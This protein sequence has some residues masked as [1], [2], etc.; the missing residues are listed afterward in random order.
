M[1]YCPYIWVDRDF[2]LARGWIQGFP[3]KLGSIWMT[4]TFGLDTPAD[5]GIRD[6][7]HVRGDVRRERAPSG[8]GHGDP[9]AGERRRADAQRPADR[10]RPP[11]PAARQGPPRRAG[12]PRAR[13]LARLR[14]LGLGDL[15]GHRRPSSSSTRPTRST[16][17]WRRRGSARASASRSATRST[18][19]RPWKSCERAGHVRVG[20]RGRG[21][22][23]QHRPLHRR[24][25]GRLGRPLRGHQPDRRP[26]AR[27]GRIRRPRRGGGRHRGGGDPRSRSG[28]RSVPTDA[29]PTSI[30]WPS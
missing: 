5:P 25:A 14:P 12:R 23:G 15:G 4:R 8:G 28:P 18:T 17:R 7:L 16:P 21:R 20:R 29:A 9:R 26:R 1:A 27:G 6:G 3:K 19:S 30:A 2:A 10:Q 22:P 11:L 13:A 24:R